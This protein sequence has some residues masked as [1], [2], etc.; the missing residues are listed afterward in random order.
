MKNLR[1][2]A[3]LPAV[4][5]FLL[6]ILALQVFADQESGGFGYT[7]IT[8]DRK[9][10]FVMLGPSDRS[11]GPYPASGMY[12]NDGSTASLWTVDWN[13]FA[14][15]PSGGEYLV[16][17]GRWP[18]WSG[19]Y[20]EEALT[21]FSNGRQLRTYT[22][23]ELID[24]PWLL[25]HSVSH[26]R[27]HL[28]W[29][30][31][32]SDDFAAL[33]V[34]EERYS[35]ASVKFDDPTQSAHVVTSL[36]DRMTFDLKTGEII[37]SKRPATVTMFAMFAVFLV[38]YTAWRMRYPDTGPGPEL[39]ASLNVLTGGVFTLSLIFIPVTAAQIFRVVDDVESESYAHFLRLSF[40]TLPR[41]VV[42][43]FGY[44]RP[45]LTSSGSALVVCF[46]VGCL[47][48]FAIIDRIV[49]KI[50]ERFKRKQIT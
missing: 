35:N 8:R 21:F 23:A 39:M 29:N 10:L 14:L 24:L 9:H 27:W 1:T 33:T 28:S 17:L 6:A 40:E 41:Y 13:A 26:Y 5:A 12:L 15:V 37:S 48:V 45:E 36:G 47:V 46:W 25:P 16:R 44:Y 34:S 2:T 20:R 32:E 3:R 18:R 11:D 31:R 38:T 43:R 30:P 4:I 49:G 7:A 22:T 19:H 50:G 42:A